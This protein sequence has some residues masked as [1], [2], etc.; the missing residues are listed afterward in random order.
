V[1]ELEPRLGPPFHRFI[2]LLNQVPVQIPAGRIVQVRRRLKDL[3]LDL[4][5]PAPIYRQS[6][7]KPLGYAGD[8]VTMNIAYTDHYQ[9]ETAYAKYLNR[10][11]CDLAV[12]RAAISRLDYLRQWIGFTVHDNRSA[13]T[14]ILSVACGPAREVRD[15]LSSTALKREVVF[16]LADQDVRALAFAQAEL[17]PYAGPGRPARVEAV[18]AAVKHLIREPVRFTHLA[19]QNLI[20]AAGLLDYMPPDAA[21]ALLRALFGLLAPGGALVASNLSPCCDS[22]GFLE[23]L[24]DWEMIYRTDDELLSLAAGLPG[25]ATLEREATGVNSFLV[26]RR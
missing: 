26:L 8:Y 13:R 11:F 16:S 23:S 7:L 5:L 18:N 21:R 14:R 17:A 6:L 9:G 19:G 25:A 1:K 3:L 20:Y 4:L 24:V 22:R 15:Y 12:S 2:R 10:M